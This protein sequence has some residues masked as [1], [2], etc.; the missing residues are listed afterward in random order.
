MAQTPWAGTGRL[1]GPISLLSVINCDQLWQQSSD[2]W[3][4]LDKIDL[5]YE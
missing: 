4:F 5:S 3:H 2:V 1:R